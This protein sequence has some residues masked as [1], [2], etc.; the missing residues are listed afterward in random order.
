MTSYSYLRRSALAVTHSNLDSATRV[1][2]RCFLIIF[3]SKRL[4]IVTHCI[5]AHLVRRL[6]FDRVLIIVWPGPPILA[7]PA[8]DSVIRL[9]D[10]SR[11]DSRLVIGHV[12]IC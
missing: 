6:N 1:A 8:W 3:C 11:A 12:L 5:L 4:R 7:V 2:V 10:V 9:K